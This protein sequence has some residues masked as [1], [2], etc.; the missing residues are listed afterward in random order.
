MSIVKGQSF[1]DKTLTEAALEVDDAFGTHDPHETNWHKLFGTPERAADT[2]LAM[3]W[4]LMGPC[5]RVNCPMN[6]E[7]DGCQLRHGAV[8]Y[9]REEVLDD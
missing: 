6:D 4:G 5:F 9:L 3:C 8:A 1:A 7:V 2:L